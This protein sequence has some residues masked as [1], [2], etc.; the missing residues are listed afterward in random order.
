MLGSEVRM[1]MCSHLL[2][3]ALCA[4]ESLW[5]R[6]GGETRQGR[7]EERGGERWWENK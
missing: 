2:E 5:E 1:K 6:G 4:W 7:R 3:M